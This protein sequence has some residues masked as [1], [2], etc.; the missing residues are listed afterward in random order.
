MIFSSLNFNSNG[1]LFF[2]ANTS[3]LSIKEAISTLKESSIIGSNDLFIASHAKSI[4]ATLVTNNTKEFNRVSNLNIEDWS[5][6]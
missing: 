5:H 2:V 1:I 3:I 4:D 6:N